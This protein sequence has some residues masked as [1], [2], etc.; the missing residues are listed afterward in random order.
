M[1][2]STEQETAEVGIVIISGSCC[3]P[4]MAPLDERVRRL[5]DQAVSET[6]VR[7]RV[8]IAP[9]ATAMAGG[10]PPEMV[11][12]LF[13]D[14]SQSGRIGLPAILIDGKAI[15]FGLPGVETLKTALLHAAE[16]RGQ[17]VSAH[18]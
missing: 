11:S 4:G 13:R 17:G 3:I 8:G 2:D 1:T 15:S 7:A 6:G 14:F 5:V 12:Q 18:E 16:A 9:A 10:L